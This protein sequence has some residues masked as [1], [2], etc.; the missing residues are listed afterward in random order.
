VMNE[1]I[2]EQIDTPINVYE[3]PET[4]FVASFIGSPAMNLLTGEG[5]GAKGINLAGGQTVKPRDT[6]APDSGRKVLLGVRPEHLTLVRSGNG[7]LEMSVMAV[8]ALGAD[9]MAHGVLAGSNGH[10]EKIIARLPGNAKVREGDVL[11]LAISPGMAHLFDVATGNRIHGLK[12]ETRSS[13]A[14]TRSRSPAS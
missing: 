13:S 5:A 3:Q 10:A 9:T 11:P 1:G 6:Q 8:E 14:R 12:P 4:T 7:D 2:A